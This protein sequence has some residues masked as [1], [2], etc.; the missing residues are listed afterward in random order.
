MSVHLLCMDSF[1]MSRSLFNGNVP[2][3]SGHLVDTNAD[4]DVFNFSP[5]RADS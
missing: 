4:S 2:E 5:A 3:M 1:P